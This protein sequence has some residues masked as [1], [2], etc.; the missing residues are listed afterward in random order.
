MAEEKM[1]YTQVAAL[2]F[3]II[4][5]Q[6]SICLV[7][8]RETN[9]WVIPKGWPKLGVPNYEMAA[10]EAKQEAGLIGDIEK[11]SIGTYTY[12]KKLHVFATI[13]CKVKVYPL[14]V[15]QQLL[16]WD[17]QGQRENFWTTVEDAISKVDE[18]ELQELLSK[19][20]QIKKRSKTLITLDFGA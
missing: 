12:K 9:R 4:D 11:K 10:I 5:G 17:E 7:T 16:N 13:V 15:T 2:P 18:T 19:N 3:T 14:N 6:V 8:S 20:I 1:L